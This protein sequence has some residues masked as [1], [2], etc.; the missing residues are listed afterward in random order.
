MLFCNRR[1]HI[2]QY[3]SKAHEENVKDDVY[4]V[5][6]ARYGTVIDARLGY[7]DVKRQKNRW[8][9]KASCINPEWLKKGNCIHEVT[10]WRD[11]TALFE[12]HGTTVGMWELSQFHLS[13]HLTKCLCCHSDIFV[14]RFMEVATE[15]LHKLHVYHTLAVF[16]AGAFD[17]DVRRVIKYVAV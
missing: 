3:S 12:F 13:N 7:F 10:V 4:W 5:I 14:A 8:I 16:P 15:L 17:D 9:L 6:A 1:V 2:K 11:G